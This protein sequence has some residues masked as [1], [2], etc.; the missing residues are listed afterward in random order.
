[1]LL[2]WRSLF[3]IRGFLDV[4]DELGLRLLLVDGSRWAVDLLAINIITSPRLSGSGTTTEPV[5]VV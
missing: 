4:D 5:A 3:W 2:L 1:M